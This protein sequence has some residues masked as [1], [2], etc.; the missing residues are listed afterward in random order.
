MHRL[1]AKDGV[2]P[3]P[4]LRP[5]EAHA[6]EDGVWRAATWLSSLGV[7]ELLTDTLLFKLPRSSS[8]SDARKAAA[9]LELPFLRALGGSASFETVHELLCSSPLLDRLANAIWDGLQKLTAARAATVRALPP[10]CSLSCLPALWQHAHSCPVHRV[11]S[12]TTNSAQTAARS[13]SATEDCRASSRASLG[14][15]ASHRPCYAR[16]WHAS[17]AVHPTRTSPFTRAIVRTH[18]LAARYTPRGAD[19]RPPRF[20]AALLCESQTAQTPARTWSGSSSSIPTS[21]T[22]NT[23]T[24]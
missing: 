22:K 14:S 11:L 2:L 23:P 8:G 10:P 19:C 16:R 9:R 13:P 5:A 18:V 4:T 7:V 20:H 6:A 3:A 1:K 17:T 21:T 24:Y 12:S 15:S